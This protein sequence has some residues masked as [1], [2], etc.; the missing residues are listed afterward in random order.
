[1]IQT[2]PGEKHF[3]RCNVDLVKQAVNDKP[4]IRTTNRG[5]VSWSNIQC[6]DQNRPVI[7]DLT[8]VEVHV[9]LVRRMVERLETLIFQGDIVYH[10][11]CIVED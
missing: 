4:S 10:S 1:M 2:A 8:F 5:H 3:V 9:G 6:C 11:I 7:S